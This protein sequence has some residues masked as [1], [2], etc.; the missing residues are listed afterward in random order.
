M[1]W[2]QADGAGSSRAGSG[3]TRMRVAKRIKEWIRS[4]S[5]VILSGLVVYDVALESD[6]W[7]GGTA[8]DFFK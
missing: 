2:N 7:P 4:N 1:T 5:L 3:G 6:V 8:V